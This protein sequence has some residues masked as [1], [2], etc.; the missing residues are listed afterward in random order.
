[1]PAPDPGSHAG[2]PGQRI[3]RLPFTIRLVRDE[4]SLLKAVQVRHEAYARHNP[5]FAEKLKH[6]EPDDTA[7]D[8]VVL[9]AEGKCDERPLGSLRLRINFTRP[10]PFAHQVC[11]PTWLD[12]QRQA[13]ARRLGIQSGQDSRTVRMALF[14]AYFLHLQQRQVAW[15]LVAARPPLTRMYERLM[16][17]DILNGATF[18]PDPALNAPHKVLAFEVTSAQARWTHA[19][20]PLLDFMVHTSHPDIEVGGPTCVVV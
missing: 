14:K 7:D 12:G 13:D 20:H 18:V 4:A 8:C 3:E 16:F 5:A 11:M 15:S 1:M 2:G 9:L 10:L 19:N 6:P 17:Q